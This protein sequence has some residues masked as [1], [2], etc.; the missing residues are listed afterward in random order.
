M[1]C[2]TGRAVI[3]DAESGVRL[4]R[5]R[6]RALEMNSGMPVQVVDATGLQLAQDFDWF[7]STIADQRAN[8]VVWDNLRL[9]VG[10][11]DEDKSG[12]M[13]PMLGALARLARDT[14]SANLLLHHRPKDPL[15]AWRGSTAIRD[16]ADALVVLE[17]V[18]GDPMRR[19][20]RRLWVSKFRIDEEPEDRW[21]TI[22][23]DR[24]GIVHLRE[25][26]AWDGQPGAPRQAELLPRVV[27]LLR[28][29]TEPLSMRAMCRELD[30]SEGS[31]ALRAVL[32]TLADDGAARRNG[33]GW[34]WAAAPT[35]Q[36]PA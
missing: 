26:A 13:A 3:F 33:R 1:D 21:L 10:S 30:I 24:F 35:G 18:K 14:G 11:A 23:R 19:H 36:P 4:M 29:A 8:L 7:A 15:K 27:D 32:D 28:A 34:E 22:K 25:A 5:R 6:L 16:Q 20:R 17:R 2:R 9:L 12:D 31:S